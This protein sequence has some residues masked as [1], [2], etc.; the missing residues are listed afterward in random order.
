MPVR[1]R[2]R[3]KKVLFPGVKRHRLTLVRIVGIGDARKA[4]CICDCGELT[5]VFPRDFGR[6]KSCG[7]IRKDAS[8]THGMIKHPIYNTWGHMKERCYSRSAT[9][10]KDY[11]GRGITVCDRWLESFENFR[12][13]MLP[14]WAPGLSLERKDND[15]PYSPGNCKWATRKEQQ[16]NKRCTVSGIIYGDL[17]TLPEAIE[18]Y[19]AV[20]RDIARGRIKRGWD[21]QEAV[22]T[23]SRVKAS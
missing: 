7:C 10:Y 12:D 16:R 1:R 2:A 13:D 23:P 8:T 20:K 5:T 19:G 21:F 17:L 14:T 4:E 18:L 15:G 11:G 22:T 6:T 3:A 9:N